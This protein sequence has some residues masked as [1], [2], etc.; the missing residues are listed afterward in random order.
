MTRTASSARKHEEGLIDALRLR[1]L[2]TPGS[3]SARH[4]PRTEE[5]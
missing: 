5:K 3:I 1:L 2:S 4:S